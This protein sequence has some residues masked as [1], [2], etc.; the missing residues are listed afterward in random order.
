MIP[1]HVIP[2]PPEGENAALPDGGPCFLVGA[3]GVYRQVQNPFY[4]ARVKAEKLAHL[5]EIEESV[6]LHV[7]KVPAGV[8]R[9]VESFFAEVYDRHQSEAVVLLAC[10]PASGQWQ[11]QVPDQI[12]NLMSYRLIGES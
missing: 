11:V 12:Q 6:Q 7:S 8:F 1:I 5:A 2:R 4:T 3:G 10:N 9:E